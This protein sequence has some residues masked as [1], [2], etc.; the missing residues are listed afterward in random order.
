MAHLSRDPHL[1]EGFTHGEDVHRSTAAR[2]FHIG[3][4]EVT[5]EQR[6]QAKVA[7]FGIICGISPFG[8]SQ[9]MG[10]PRGEAK[11][12]IEEYFRSYPEVKDYIDN[13][14]ASARERGYVETVFGRKRFLPDINSRNQ[15]V[16]GLAER[17]AVNA[18]VQGS[19]ADIIKLAMINVFRRFREEGLKSR[20]VLQVH[21]EL[22]FDVVAGERDKGMETVKR[23]MEN[24][25]SLL[26]PLTVECNYGKNWLEAH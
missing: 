23:E 6:R 5:A 18:P 12:F 13:S 21:D 16:R 15:T 10:I 11:L 9:R 25:C 1:I 8:L 19:A 2:I 3:P 22:V 14:V 26:V 24:V 20:M 17:N 7:N 4:Q